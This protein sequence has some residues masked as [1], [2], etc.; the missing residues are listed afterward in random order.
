MT[1]PPLSSHRFSFYR[2][3]K[4]SFMPM[5]LCRFPMSG[6][7]DFTLLR[8]HGQ[9]II[10]PPLHRRDFVRAATAGRLSGL[11][12]A[13]VPWWFRA[14]PIRPAGRPAGAERG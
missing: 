11:L 9:R 12:R 6:A 14:S 1:A 5:A 7:Q 4:L 10:D 13:W 2:N 8:A 3:H